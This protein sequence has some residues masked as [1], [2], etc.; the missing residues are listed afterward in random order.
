MDS[1]D[2]QVIAFTK[3]FYQEHGVIPLSRRIIKFIQEK[4][5]PEFDSIQFQERYT[6]KPLRVIAERAGLPRPVQC[7]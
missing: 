3:D 5:D 4:L 6:D 7:I 2:Q 1:F